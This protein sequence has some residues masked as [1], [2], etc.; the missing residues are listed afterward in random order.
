M[1]GGYMYKGGE[2]CDTKN[3]AIGFPGRRVSTCDEAYRISDTSG[4]T[5]DGEEK[6]KSLQAFTISLGK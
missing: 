4:Q 1:N 5:G 6:S 2:V 3:M